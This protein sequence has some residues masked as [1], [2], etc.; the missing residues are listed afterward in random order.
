MPRGMR[1]P[2]I[3]GVVE[4]GDDRVAVLMELVVTDD[5]PWDLG[6]FA[7]PRTCSVA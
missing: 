2:A 5:S 4:L 6:R 3:H 7:A 1:M